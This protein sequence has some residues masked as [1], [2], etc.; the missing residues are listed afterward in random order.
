MS[1]LNYIKKQC[2][3]NKKKHYLFIAIN[4]NKIITLLLGLGIHAILLQSVGKIYLP[5]KSS[6]LLF[7]ILKSS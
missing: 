1:S 3:I 2:K 4:L 5:K 6:T 7:M